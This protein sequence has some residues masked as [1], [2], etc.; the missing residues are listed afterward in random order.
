M[1]RQALTLLVHLLTWNKGINVATYFQPS[2]YA[3]LGYSGSFVLLLTGINNL[4]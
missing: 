3:A 4:V 1:D 2:L